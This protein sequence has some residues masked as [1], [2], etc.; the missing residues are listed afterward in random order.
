MK[1]FGF[2][3]V[4]ALLSPAPIAAQCLMG[5]PEA[6]WRAPLEQFD[7]KKFVDGPQTADAWAE[8][9][10]KSLPQHK[11]RPFLKWLAE[12]LANLDRP[13]QNQMPR[14]N[15]LQPWVSED[16]DAREHFL[17]ARARVKCF[18]EALYAALEHRLEHELE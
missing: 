7:A 13:A 12:G 14:T 11:V 2:A 10:A 6:E 16:A 3:L 5:T 1:A 9:F 15:G 17:R 8:E 18:G 4:F